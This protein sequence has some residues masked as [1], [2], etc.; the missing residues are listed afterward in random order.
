MNKTK[1]F[2]QDE[3]LSHQQYKALIVFITGSAVSYK[4][5]QLYTNLILF[6]TSELYQTVAGRKSEPSLKLRGSCGLEI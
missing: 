2:T 4:H 5:K 6:V 3:V 1:H